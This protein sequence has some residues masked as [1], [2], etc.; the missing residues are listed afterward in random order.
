M[1]VS[2]V[3][4]PVSVRV[5]DD[6]GVTVDMSTGL[7]VQVPVPSGP[8]GRKGDPGDTPAISVTDITGGHRVSITTGN[9]TVT[10]DVMDGENGDTGPGVASGGSAGQ[11][12]RKASSTD[13]DTEWTDESVS[14]VNG[15]TG[16]VELN[17]ADVGAVAVA[18]GVGHAGEFLVVGTNG[19]VTTMTLSTWQGGSY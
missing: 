5:P 9:D 12:L 15:K 18:Q 19:D 6:N 3:C 17:A 8:P 13:F 11:V 4:P 1:A 16:A 10:F 7:G 14:S 2:Y